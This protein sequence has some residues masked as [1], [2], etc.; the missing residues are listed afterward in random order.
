[1]QASPQSEPPL[2]NIL[3]EDAD[4]LV[5]LKPAGLVCHPTKGAPSSSLVG[6]MRLYLGRAGK[7]VAGRSAV[8]AKSPASP[9]QPADAGAPG[10]DAPCPSL[11]LIHRLDRETSG[12]VLAAKN[13]EAAGELGRMVEKRHLEK[14][15]LAIVHGRLERDAGRIEAPLGKDLQSAVAIK[16]C[17]RPDGVPA[18]TEF[19]V[20]AR[21][22]QAGRSFSLVKA[23]PLTG[24]K[25][26]LR[27]HLAHLGHPVVGDKIYGGDER[28]YLD[29]VR[30][31]LTPAQERELIL[32]HHALH[33][34]GLRFT[35]RA[36]AWEFH[37]QP[38][39]W[40][41]EFTRLR[42]IA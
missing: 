14:E 10:Q 21:F 7:G 28:L 35:W 29:F 26:Q 11:H 24:R 40:F 4:L 39:P 18:A 17:V 31:R 3:Y 5:L 22:T 36:R 8:T 20:E 37:A 27:I 9:A 25:H 33:A 41:V 16:D 6:R 42:S 13:P 15:Y 1:M 23:R 19:R 32:P 30:G 2:L 34:A 38:E 12:L